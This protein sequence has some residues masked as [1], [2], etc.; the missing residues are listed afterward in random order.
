M[1]KKFVSLIL[2]LFLFGCANLRGQSDTQTGYQPVETQPESESVTHKYYDFD[3]IPI[4][5]EMKINV[6][7]SI[8]Y[9]SQNIRSGMLLF[10]GRVNSDSLF[11]YFQTS[12][13]NEGW[14]LIS[15]IKYGTYIMT[16]EKPNKLCI[17]R[18][19]DRSFTSELQIWISPKL[20]ISG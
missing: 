18:I 6:K 19:I 15:Y 1:L 16:F 4:P 12:M 14:K 9:E 8:L 2:V 17:I 11:S 13:S 7:E 10:S 20:S 3:D 5:R